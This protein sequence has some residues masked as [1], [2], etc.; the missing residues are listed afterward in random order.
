MIVGKEKLRQITEPV[1]TDVFEFV[2]GG[3]NFILAQVLGQFPQDFGVL[4]IHFPSGDWAGHEYGWLS[5]EQLDAFRQADADLAQLLAA[6]EK[7]GLRSE[8][9]IIITADHGGHKTNHGSRRAEDMTIPWIIA[10][11]G[12][13]PMQLTIPVHTT[14]TAA[15]AA[16]ALGLP[17]PPEWAGR[18]VTEAFGLPSLPRP[19]VVCP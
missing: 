12:V 19:Q 6:L 3:D 9:L 15:T 18:P 7:S 10:G 5:D 14:D 11:P 13:I 8:T 17:I 16:W 1:S 2:D 4:F